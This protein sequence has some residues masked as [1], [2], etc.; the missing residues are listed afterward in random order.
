MYCKI[1]LN[2]PSFEALEVKYLNEPLVFIDVFNDFGP[3]VIVTDPECCVAVCLD[4]ELSEISGALWPTALK[5][6][7]VVLVQLYLC[8]LVDTSGTEVA[9]HLG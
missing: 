3:D 7:F 1:V 4:D 8:A 9:E 5:L 6:W 2:C